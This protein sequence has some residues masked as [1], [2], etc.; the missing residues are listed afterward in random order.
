MSPE[1]FSALLRWTSTAVG[2]T[3]P[4]DYDL[5]RAMLSLA[6]GK[7]RFAGCEK[8]DAFSVRITPNQR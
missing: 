4:N 6:I 7:A 8:P 1:L 2:T 5:E 3:L